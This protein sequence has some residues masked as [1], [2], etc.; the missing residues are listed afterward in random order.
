MA[1][2]QTVPQDNTDLR[3]IKYF[4]ASQMFQDKVFELEHDL[5]DG[6]RESMWIRWDLDRVTGVYEAV[7][8]TPLPS[9]GTAR[10]APAHLSK[11]NRNFAEINQDM[12]EWIY[13][14]IEDPDTVSYWKHQNEALRPTYRVRVKHRGVSSAATF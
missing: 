1:T 12:P 5:P 3:V 7:I 4:S 14:D 9:G 10:P 8:T 11:I 6:T 2:Q 13:K